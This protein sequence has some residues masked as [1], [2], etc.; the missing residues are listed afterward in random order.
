[1][2]NPIDLLGIHPD[3]AH[4]RRL[5][6]RDYPYNP[7][8]IAQAGAP[9]DWTTG[10]DV[11][12]DINFTLPTKDQGSSGSCGGQSFGYYGQ[13]LGV[14][15]GLD[16]SER[17]AKYLYSQVY[18]PF[19]GGSS[20]REL[21]SI[22]KKQGFGLE[23]LTPSYNN[24]AAPTEAFME[25]PQDISAA[26]RISA[27]RNQLL[28]AYAFPALDIDSLGQAVAACKGV[29]FGITGSNNGTWLSQNPLP[30][31]PGAAT[32][33]HYMYAGKAAIVN[34]QRGI[35]AKQSWGKNVGFNG[36]QFI[37]EHYVSTNNVWAA[38][39]LIVNPKPVAPPQYNFSADISVGARGESV[40]ALQQFLAY[41]G[42]FNLAPT[43]YYG[44]VTAGA[45][46]RFQLKYGVASAAALEELGGHVVGPATRRKL[47]SLT[48]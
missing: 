24:G 13:V 17:S 36:W 5:D 4:P 26:A 14:G 8:E 28:L 39:S 42:V 15:N 11:E 20:D 31:L 25:R 19:G 35:W 10:Y 44:E 6:P 7:L 33:R 29:V 32:W 21:A 46:L 22:A 12:K 27:S 47:N 34:G 2:K 43:G 38:I 41:D 16:K 37:D 45:V 23:S 30:P 18:N 40:T 9:F 3:G 48:K 1:M